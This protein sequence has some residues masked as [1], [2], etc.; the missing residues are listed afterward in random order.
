LISL[1]VGVASYGEAEFDLAGFV[2]QG[3]AL[4]VEGSRLTLIQIVLQGIGMDPITSLYYYAPV[5]LFFN[6]LILLPTEGMAPLFAV[7][8]TVGPITLFLNACITLCLNLSSVW[9]IGKASGLV[10]TLSGVVKDVVLISGSFMFLG[11]TIT[12]TQIF[13]YAI[14]V[15]GF[16]L[17]KTQG[18]K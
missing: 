8:S 14:A 5:C 7:F 6:L 4:I 2:V 10:L 1:G 17:F 3:L 15:V 16:V 18:S 13:G 9:L 12:Q 11:S